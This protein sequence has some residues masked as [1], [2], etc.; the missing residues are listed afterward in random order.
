MKR[1]I[2]PAVAAGLLAFVLVALARASPAVFGTAGRN[3][4]WI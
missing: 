3:G 2:I 4:R 1:Y